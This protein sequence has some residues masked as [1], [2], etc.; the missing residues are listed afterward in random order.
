MIHKCPDYWQDVPADNAGDAIVAALGAA[1]VEY[2][3]FTSGSEIGFYQEALAKAHALG[4]PAPRI[5]TVTHEHASLNA[6]IGYALVSGKPA[7][8]AVHVDVG[9]MHHGGAV[10]TAMHANAPVVMTAGYP[11][12]S[13]T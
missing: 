11:P 2:L 1:G 3:F 13:Y 7:V 8:T 10:H 9:T 5:I 12:T 4:R 6:A